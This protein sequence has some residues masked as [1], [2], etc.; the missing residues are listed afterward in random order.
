MVAVPLLRPRRQDPLTTA[1]LGADDVI[2]TSEVTS[3]VTVAI[4]ADDVE[5]VAYATSDACE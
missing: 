5:N 3:D 1:T 4:L 2:L